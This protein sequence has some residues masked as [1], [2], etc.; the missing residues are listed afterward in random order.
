MFTSEKSSRYYLP[1]VIVSY[2]WKQKQKYTPQENKL[3]LAF[4]TFQKMT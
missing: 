2:Y 4:L 1:V 3:I